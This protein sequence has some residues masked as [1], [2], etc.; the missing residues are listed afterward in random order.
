[1]ATIATKSIPLTSA[2]KISRPHRRLPPHHHPVEPGP[3]AGSWGWDWWDSRVRIQW[4]DQG[5]L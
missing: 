4:T 1:V 3:G 5:Q 2:A